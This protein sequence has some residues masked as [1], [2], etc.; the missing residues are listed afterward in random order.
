MQTRYCR[1]PPPSMAVLIRRAFSVAAWMPLV[2]HRSDVSVPPKLAAKS[3]QGCT[4]LALRQRRCPH[5]C[6]RLDFEFRDLRCQILN[7]L[8]ILLRYFADILYRIVNLHYSGSHL[9]HTIGDNAG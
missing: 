5:I 9:I 7:T 8:L 3:V 1:E 6:K 2:L 4:L